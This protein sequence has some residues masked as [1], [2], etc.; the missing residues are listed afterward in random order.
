MEKY[1]TKSDLELVIV[2]K[3]G[4]EKE[5]QKLHANIAKDVAEFLNDKFD[6]SG[7]TWEIKPAVWGASATKLPKGEVN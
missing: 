3:A 4:D 2:V 7:G 6:S 5:A 1:L